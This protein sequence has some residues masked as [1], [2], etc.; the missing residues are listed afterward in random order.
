MSAFRWHVP[1]VSWVD[2]GL[3]ETLGDGYTVIQSNAFDRWII[4]GSLPS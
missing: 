4:S 3:A 2:K 1:F